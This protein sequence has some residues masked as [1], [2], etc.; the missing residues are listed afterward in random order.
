MNHRSIGDFDLRT[1]RQDGGHF[2]DEFTAVIGVQRIVGHVLDQG[3]NFGIGE[4]ENRS[5]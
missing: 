3:Q 2:T 4:L 1:D 5:I